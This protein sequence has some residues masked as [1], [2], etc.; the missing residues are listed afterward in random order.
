MTYPIIQH[1]YETTAEKLLCAIGNRDFYSGCITFE[2]GSK[3]CR[4]IATLILYRQPADVVP[5]WW[6]FHT[7]DEH[8]GECANDFSFSELK[9]FLLP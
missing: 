1:L 6:E 8:G 3:L 4:L 7:E 2:Y 5:V 9:P